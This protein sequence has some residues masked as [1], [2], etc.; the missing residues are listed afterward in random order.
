MYKNDWDFVIQ[1][2]PQA[3]EGE[4]QSVL[5]TDEANQALHDAYEWAKAKADTSIYAAN[6]KVYIEAI[7]M[8]REYEPNNHDRADHI[9]L[10]YILGN[11]QKWRG[12]TAR[13]SKKILNAYCSDIEN[14]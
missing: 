14:A 8:N 1:V 5:K 7:E 10:L 6:A 2:G 9:Q 12:D 4:P 13:Q 3:P 11:L